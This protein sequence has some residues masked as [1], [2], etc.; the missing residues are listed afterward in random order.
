MKKKLLI[1]GASGFLGYHLLRLA[2]RQWEVY[3]FTNSNSA[4][5]PFATILKC[6]I[7]NYIALGDYFEDIEPDAVIHTAAIADANFCQRNKELSYSVNVE[8]SKNIAGICCD[9]NIPFAFTS[10]D[11]VF[12]GKQG[13]Y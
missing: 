8:A 5:F 1:T 7:T 4:K 12:D 6:D 13:M 10:T 3:G 9:L 2:T 11:L